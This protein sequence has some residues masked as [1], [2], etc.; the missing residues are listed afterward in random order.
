MNLTMMSNALLEMK[1][2]QIDNFLISV[3]LWGCQIQVKICSIVS[4]GIWYCPCRLFLLLLT[5]ECEEV[6][7]FWRSKWRA[8]CVIGYRNACIFI[9]LLVNAILTFRKRKPAT[10]KASASKG[11]KGKKNQS[12]EEGEIGSDDDK[13]FDDGLDEDLIGKF[14]FIPPKVFDLLKSDDATTTR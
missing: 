11:R 9:T 1:G 10:K 2:Y 4:R 8:F 7:H 14:Y 5:D 6:V 3:L 13:E 12:E